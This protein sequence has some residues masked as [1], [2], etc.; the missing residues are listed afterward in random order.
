MMGILK[1]AG[2]TFVGFV[3]IG[4]FMPDE[5]PARSQ[6]QNNILPAL[7]QRCFENKK[8][9]DY[10]HYRNNQKRIPYII[11]EDGRF[12]TFDDGEIWVGYTRQVW[13]TGNVTFGDSITIRGQRVICKPN[14][15]AY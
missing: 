15:E 11:K 1:I 2:W 8:V 14:G 9:M 4:A 10:I 3:A 7:Y 6:S 5:T 12:G 13:P